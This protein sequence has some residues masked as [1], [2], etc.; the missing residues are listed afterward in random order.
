M[1]QLWFTSKILSENYLKQ[2]PEDFLGYSPQTFLLGALSFQIIALPFYR[3]GLSGVGNTISDMGGAIFLMLALIAAFK[4]RAIK[5]R[6]SAEEKESLYRPSVWVYIFG[7]LLTNLLYI[8]FK[9][10]YDAPTAV[11][12]WL[13]TFF[14]VVLIGRFFGI[15]KRKKIKNPE[16]DIKYE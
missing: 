5:K 14:L 7:F 8:E 13:N 3:F 11:L 9:Q 1:L 16:L 10:S 4:W 15:L 2:T 12:L 6:L